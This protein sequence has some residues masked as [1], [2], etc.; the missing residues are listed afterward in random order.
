MTVYAYGVSFG[1]EEYILN[2]TRMLVV[3]SVLV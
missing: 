1:G 3:H 2:S